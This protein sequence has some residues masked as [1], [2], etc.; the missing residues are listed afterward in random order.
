MGALAQTRPV[1]PRQ[2]L[3]GL[4]SS[5]STGPSS[6]EGRADPWLYW[7]RLKASLRT[8]VIIDHP[9]VCRSQCQSPILSCSAP[10]RPISGDSDC[11]HTHLCPLPSLCTSAAA[12]GPL[13]QSWNRILYR[14]AAI[15]PICPATTH[16]N[17]AFGLENWA[18]R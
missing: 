4:P 2:P 5:P 13:F 12:I 10:E 1:R 14:R 7:S 6:R 15:A 8:F 18:A 16:G 3:I 17:D 9:S 11:H